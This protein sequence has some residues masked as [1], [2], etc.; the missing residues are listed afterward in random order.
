VPPALA[1]LFGLYEAGDG[2]FSP[3]EIRHVREA[4]VRPLHS[5]H[6][7]MSRIG[8]HFGLART[9]AASAPVRSTPSSNRSIARTGTRNSRPTLIV[10]ISPRS[11]ALYELSRL[12]SKYFFPASGTDIV[13]GT[14][15]VDFVIFPA[16]VS[17]KN[18]LQ[19]TTYVLDRFDAI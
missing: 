15:P 12:R 1:T 10:G 13:R 5:P 16:P 14:S 2:V 7:G 17:A 4:A 3:R 9:Q 18:D 8:H 11:A 19:N 6:A